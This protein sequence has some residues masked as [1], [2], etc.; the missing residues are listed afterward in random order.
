MESSWRRNVWDFGI[1]APLPSSGEGNGEIGLAATLLLND[2]FFITDI[3]L[4]DP[5]VVPVF[6]KQ[7]G[8]SACVIVFDLIKAAGKTHFPYGIGVEPDVH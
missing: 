5:S 2:H 1:T 3:H 4:A 8:S 7:S 6:A